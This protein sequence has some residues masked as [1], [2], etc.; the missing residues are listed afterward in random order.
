[1]L[2]NAP[3]TR[4]T[5]CMPALG[6]LRTFAT[7]RTAASVRDDAHLCAISLIAVPVPQVRVVVRFATS[8]REGIDVHALG[9]RQTTHRKSVPHGLRAVAA[10]VPFGASEAVLGVSAA[11]LAGGHVALDELWDRA[12]F[13]R[14]FTRLHEATDDAAAAAVLES[15]LAERIPRAAGLVARNR[16]MQRAAAQLTHDNVSVVA[17]QLGISERHLRRMFHDT[18]GLSP[19]SYAKLVRFHRALE[20]ARAHEAPN[21]ATIAASAGYYDQAHLISDFRAITGAT[22]RALMKELRDS[23]PLG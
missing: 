12:S 16:L 23:A 14:L 5:H 20:Q 3:P 18:V 4:H 15:T 13:Q 11:A 8:L 1:M 17:H 22:P 21:W 2:R 7:R 19:K 6:A 9:V 10:R